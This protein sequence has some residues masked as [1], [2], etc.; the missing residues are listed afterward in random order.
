MIGARPAA[1]AQASSP[2][3]GPGS[4][5]VFLLMGQCV[6]KLREGGLDRRRISIALR[7]QD[8]LPCS[9]LAAVRRQTLALAKR[10]PDR[11]F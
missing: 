8:D 9:E 3:C 4:S 10:A 2:S 1:S 11:A 5:L 6:V 7:G